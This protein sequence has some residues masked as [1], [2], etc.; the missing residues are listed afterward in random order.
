MNLRSSK[1]SFVRFL[2]LSGTLFVF[3]SIDFTRM[4]F[5]MRYPDIAIYRVPLYVWSVLAKSS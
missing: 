5:D 3:G 1:K 4:F 2:H